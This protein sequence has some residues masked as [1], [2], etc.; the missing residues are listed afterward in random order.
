MP[1]S[2]YLPSTN[3]SPRLAVNSK[4]RRWTGTL[5][6]C[7]GPAYRVNGNPAPTLK[8]KNQGLVEHA[9]LTGTTVGALFRNLSPAQV[10]R[11]RKEYHPQRCCDRHR[12]CYL[13]VVMGSVA[14]MNIIYII[15]L[16]WLVSKVAMPIFGHPLWPESFSLVHARDIPEN[17]T[18]CSLLG[19]FGI[20][21]MSQSGCSWCTSS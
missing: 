18:P 1:S 2:N 3:F 11:S 15:L 5:S 7:D 21:L 9:K 10:S 8:Y 19:E 4:K 12:A 14:D 20:L 17:G 16:S 13:V 6:N